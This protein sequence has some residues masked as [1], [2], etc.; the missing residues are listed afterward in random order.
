MMDWLYPLPIF[1]MTVI[2]VIGIAVVCVL[3]YLIVFAFAGRGW[4]PAFKAMSPVLLTPLAVVFGL[5]I[6][7][8]P[9]GA[10]EA[11]SSALRAAFHIPCWN[12]RAIAI[13]VIAS[14]ARF[15][16]NRSSTSTN[17]AIR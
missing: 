16:M 13:G 10:A 12:V 14:T 5:I 9:A 11:V 1:W 7:T 15:A 6:E 17:P 2:V 3:I 4:T 8:A